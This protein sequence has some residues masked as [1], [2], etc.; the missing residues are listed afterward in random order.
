MKFEAPEAKETLREKTVLEIGC[1]HLPQVLGAAHLS[2]AYMNYI[3]EHKEI[4]YVALDV[5]PE[6]VASAR[7]INERV[8]RPDGI[9]KERIKFITASGDTLPFKDGSVSEI[10]MQNILGAD[11]LPFSLRENIL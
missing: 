2:D 3:R 11:Y 6:S 9:P 8:T 5:S 1:G 4:H 10:T 7:R